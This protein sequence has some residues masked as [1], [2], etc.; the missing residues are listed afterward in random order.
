MEAFTTEEH[1][2]D[3][4][5][6]Y[7]SKCKTHQPASK[8]LQIWRLPPVLVSA[9]REFENQV[10]GMRKYPECAHFFM[11][12]TDNSP[13]TIPIHEW[14]MG[15]VAESGQVSVRKPGF[16]GLPGCCTPRNHKSVSRLENEEK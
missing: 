1:L 14:E 2:S 6:Y 3:D 9:C 4:E 5:K 13:E 12:S 10:V 7:C 16:D 11:S 8:K 15:E